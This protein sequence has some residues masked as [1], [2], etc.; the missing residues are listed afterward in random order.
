MSNDRSRYWLFGGGALLG[1]A[2]AYF[3]VTGI[4]LFADRALTRRAAG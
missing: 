1:V 4:Y 3:I 2:A